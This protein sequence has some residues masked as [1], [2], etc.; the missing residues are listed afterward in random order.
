VKLPETITYDK[1]GP[2]AVI[3][4]NRPE[5]MNSLTPEMFAALSDAFDDF[6]GDDDLQV[7]ILT[8]AG[9]KSFCAGADLDQTI[10]KITAGEAAS[11]VG[12]PTKRF[13]SDIFK[14][15]IGAVNGFC[16]AGGL[17]ILQG[18]DLRIAA[19][20]AVF[21]LGEVPGLRRC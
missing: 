11:V 16:V 17:E 21:G 10:P 8:G 18:T 12:D 5:A 1:D 20:H 4:L 3:T 13:F 2:V 14:P 19:E 7:A 6:N 9:D 15:I